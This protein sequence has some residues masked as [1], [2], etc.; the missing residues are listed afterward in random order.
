MTSALQ[1]AVTIKNATLVIN[2]E[3]NAV[4]LAKEGVADSWRQY[5]GCGGM[6]SSGYST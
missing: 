2:R 5:Q 6:L 3:Q 1:D 4:T